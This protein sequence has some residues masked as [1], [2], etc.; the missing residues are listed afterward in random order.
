V[1]RAALVTSLAPVSLGISRRG[2]G[3]RSVRLE[4]DERFEIV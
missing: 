2:V 1:G 4:F 3:Y